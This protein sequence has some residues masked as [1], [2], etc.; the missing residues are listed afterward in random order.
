MAA[1]S[2]AVQVSGERKPGS[3]SRV[4]K[5]VTALA[6][7]NLTSSQRVVLTKLAVVLG[8]AAGFALSP[9]LWVGSRFYPLVPVPLHGL[10]RIPYPL[11][12]ICF[13]VLW[14]LL[15]LIAIAVRPRIYI[16]A[17]VALLL[18]L[19][20]LDQ[21]RWQPW[22]YL[23]LFMLIPFA[24]YSGRA[25]DLRGQENLLNIC[26]LIVGCT[27]FYSGLQ[28]LNSHFAVNGFPTLLGPL[29]SHLPMLHLWGWVVAAIEASV[30]IGLLTRKYRNL[31][32]LGGVSMHC[33]I[34]YTCAVVLDWN[35]VVWPWNV[36]M[37]AFLF[38][39]F[40]KADFS[41]GDAVWRNGLGYQK[42]VLLLFGVLPFFSFFG[43]WDS[44]LS[45]SLYSAN[46]PLANVFVGDTVKDELPE[47]IRRYTH[48][49][50][51]NTTIVKIQDWSLGEL[52]V[53]P[54]AAARVYRSIGE[55]ICRYSHN[56]PEVV[57]MIQEKST[58][59]GNG[60]LYRYTCFNGL[61]FDLR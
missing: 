11:D 14:L 20:L 42:I 59:L 57:L 32:V 26:R 48:K 27:Y 51:G 7:A 5:F 54:Y 16:A 6:A 56:S 34:L 49:L 61:A 33:F 55:D 30:G 38:T 19:A 10:P 23:Y 60:L 2:T 22:V 45:A 28:K 15:A 3:V 29:A 39:L 40:W 25:N 58:L 8:L 21:T 1:T 41:F 52:N 18:F 31:A 12:Y 17:F 13:G 47:R 35:S 37:I 53:P 36:A 4:G 43:W 9:K 50:Y 44:Y 46:V 24:G